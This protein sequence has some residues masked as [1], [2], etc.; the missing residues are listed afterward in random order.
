MRAVAVPGRWVWGLS[1][2]VTAVALAIPGARLISMT[3]TPPNVQVQPQATMI[4]TLTVPQPVTSLT[5]QSYGGQVQVTAGPVSR[6]HVTERI[7][8]DSPGGVVSAVPERVSGGSPSQDTQADGVPAVPE[9]V[10]GGRL[11]LGD[12]VCASSD[13]SVSFAVIVPSDVTVTVATQ[14]GGPVSVS[15]IAGADLNSDGGPVRATRIGGPLTVTTG[16]GPLT[17]NG[18][19][20]PLRADTDGGILMPGAS[21]P[22]RPP[23]PRAAARRRSPS[24]PRRPR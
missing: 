2:L 23:S 20:G 13:C 5:V 6:V 12:P 18:L 10:S 9:S 19:T 15:G 1:G 14:G 21:P 16:G 7:M 4:R 24:P 11:S 8:Y 17:V 3:G 22:P